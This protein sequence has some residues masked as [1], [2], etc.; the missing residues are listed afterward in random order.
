M[1]ASKHVWL[2]VFIC[3]HG[4]NPELSLIHYLNGLAITQ[5]HPQLPWDYFIVDTHHQIITEHA[6]NGNYYET[7]G[8][9][10]S[11]HHYRHNGGIYGNNYGLNWLTETRNSFLQNYSPPT[12]VHP[13]G[14]STP[15]QLLN[16]V[17]HS[18]PTMTVF[19]T[20][21]HPTNLA[22]HHAHV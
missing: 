12:F 20:V 1:Y 6:S 9:G 22:A 17:I 2:H 3:S 7:Y 19:H 14:Y 11:K 15:Y 8:S 4:I 13:L 16:V 18:Q 5:L 10:L 21:D